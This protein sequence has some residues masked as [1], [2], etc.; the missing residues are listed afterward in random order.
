MVGLFSHQ[1]TYTE[2]TAF[3]LHWPTYQDLGL[4]QEAFTDH[5]ECRSHSNQ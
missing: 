3:F 4:L 5:M 2:V 1:Y